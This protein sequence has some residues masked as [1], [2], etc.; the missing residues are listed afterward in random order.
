LLLSLHG[1]TWSHILRDK[2]RTGAIEDFKSDK[3]QLTGAWQK[4]H[5]KDLRVL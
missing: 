2:H 5:N 3:E 4:V 1:E